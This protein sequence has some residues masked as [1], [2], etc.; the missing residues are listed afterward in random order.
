M[1]RK[2]MH[3][4]MKRSAVGMKK[5]ILSALLALCTAALLTTVSFA[6]DKTV[7]S[8]SELA[9]AIQSTDTSPSITLSCDITAGEGDGEIT[10]SGTS[11]VRL[12]LNGHVL[13]GAMRTRIFL[14]QDGGRLVI[15]DSDAQ[16]RGALAGGS[17][18][19]ASVTHSGGGA[20]VAAGGQLE[21][22]GATIRDCQGAYGGGAVCTQGNFYM[23]NGAVIKDCET[24]H[25]GGGGAVYTTGS[26][27]RFIMRDTALIENCSFCGVWVEEGTFSM[28][29]GTIR[30]CESRSGGGGIYVSEGA[31]FTLSGGLITGNYDG[32]N[33][34]AAIY[35]AG[36]LNL[37]G[38]EI[39]DNIVDDM[40]IYWEDFEPHEGIWATY[41]STINCGGGIVRDNVYLQESARVNDDSFYGTTVFFDKMLGRGDV[42]GGTYLEECW[43]RTSSSSCIVVFFDNSDSSS[44]LLREE[45]FGGSKPIEPTWLG[46]EWVTEDGEPFDYSQT[47]TQYRTYLYRKA[48]TG[49]QADA[50]GDAAADTSGGEDTMNAGAL[51][52]TTGDTSSTVTLLLI[53]SLAGNV[54]LIVALARRKK[55]AR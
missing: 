1:D 43:Y 3:T 7:S 49:A 40:S 23:Y 21:L 41:S 32:T 42:R 5:T 44:F 2:V 39:A 18:E 38:G 27:A 16:K 24:W 13:D 34:G 53:L 30:G 51:F 15:T 22:N 28:E 26:A 36:T 14:V 19:D 47:P 9:D 50:D 52:S 6:A 45:M 54:V 31:V 25:A 55:T 12:D 8:W 46:G 17:A 20:Y 48:E 35:L 10:V 29:G 37:R 4:V 33:K 11:T